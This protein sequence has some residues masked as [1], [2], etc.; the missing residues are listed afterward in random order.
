MCVQQ[1][2]EELV[3]IYTLLE[4]YK[5]E[6]QMQNKVWIFCIDHLTFF[7]NPP[8]S[9]VGAAVF[10]A[11]V[12]PFIHIY[13]VP[14]ISG[15]GHGEQDEAEQPAQTRTDDNCPKVHFHQIKSLLWF[16]EFS[17]SEA[18]VFRSNTL[19]HVILSLLLQMCP[20]WRKNQL[21][22]HAGW[23]NT[24]FSSASSSLLHSCIWSESRSTWFAPQFSAAISHCASLAL[25]R[26][27]LF[28][29]PVLYIV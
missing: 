11:G 26:D 2:I 25:L 9:G 5:C 8:E 15:D 18:G 24:G 1:L 22:A 13:N 7:I 29:S 4:E 14:V 12:L 16:I 10:Q 28:S 17:P 19:K 20:G 23:K 27:E 21:S 6:E 3:Q